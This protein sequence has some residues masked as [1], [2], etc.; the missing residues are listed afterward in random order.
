MFVVNTT[1][2]REAVFIRLFGEGIV[3]SE[4]NF[5]R[6]VDL[7]HE[8]GLRIV[9][10]LVF[11]H[12]W[13]QHPFFQDV[14]A[15][16]AESP[17]AH[18]YQWTGVPGESNHKY[19]YSWV[20]GP[21]IN[22][23]N[24]AV[25]EYLTQV[26][27]YWV[28]NYD[29]DGYRCDVAW[30][31]EQDSA[32]FWINLNRRLKN[33]KP[34][35]FMLAEAPSSNSGWEFTG[36]TE[37]DKSILF[38]DRFAAAYDWELRPFEESKGLLGALSGWRSI[39]QLNAI[40]TDEYPPRALP[41]RFIENHDLER[42]ATI[43]DI[44]RSKLGHTIIFTAPGIPLIYGGAE[45]AQPERMEGI[46][47]ADPN[48]TEAYFTQLINARKNYIDNE[49][50]MVVLPNTNATKV[51]SYAT[52]SKN[53]IA[54]STLNFSDQPQEVT[55]D[56]ATAQ[57]Q[58]AAYPNLVDVFET[59]K[60]VVTEDFGSLIATLELYEASVIIFTD[61]EAGAAAQ[62]EAP[63]QRSEPVNLLLNGDFSAGFDGWLSYVHAGSGASAEFNP[64]DG[65]LQVEIASK[66]SDHWN[67]QIL[68]PLI[69]LVQGKTYVVTFTAAAEKPR[70]IQLAFQHDGGS[71]DTYAI[72]SI[73]LSTDS[74]TYEFSFTMMAKTD[75][76]PR[77][78]I[79]LGNSDGDVTFDDIVLYQ[80]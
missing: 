54:I 13:D 6:M 8:K 74:T 75:N 52:I 33:I 48:D 68:Q 62:S 46:M 67:I 79:E 20:D 35:I 80:K 21:N 61:I 30:G 73:S 3:G 31:V 42:A 38:D 60:S 40:L 18:F 39:A 66:G 58:I 29:I 10:D 41:L 59:G 1:L 44:P 17:Y 19:Y 34:E 26:A 16:K 15:N 23:D 25:Q 72:E 65:T 4:G 22:V 5:K 28:I 64:V 45:H 53:S 47:I 9:L 14:L 70:S 2:L 77:F 43:L 56:L 76:A 7:A 69:E 57:E 71:F 63:P 78:V 55:V 27:E 11:N 51:N 50:Q 32:T 36:S 37:H 49:S 12:T 24:P